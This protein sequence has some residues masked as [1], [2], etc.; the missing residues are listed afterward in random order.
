MPRNKPS[1]TARKVATDYLYTVEDPAVARLAPAGSIEATR[2]LLLAGGLIKPW[3]LSLIRS[4]AYRRFGDAAERATMPGHLLHLVLRKRFMDD[5]V[6]AAIDDGATQVLV[7]GAGFDTLCMRLAAEYPDTIFLE[8]DHP[9]T[10]ESKRRGVRKMGADTPKLH[11]A[12]VDLGK[13]NLNRVLSDSPHWRNDRVSAVVAEGVLMYLSESDVVA[14]LEAVRSSTAVGSRLLATWVFE[15]A[16]SSKEM[17]WLGGL[18]R[19]FLRLAGE[20]F[21]WGVSDAG[22]VS[23]LAAHG[24]GCDEASRFDLGTRY[25]IP[26]GEGQRRLATFERVVAATS[27]A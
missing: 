3:M 13:Q 20:P 5:E 27:L 7:V 26:A 8:V 24:F 10:S 14:F 6:R 19:V 17:G 18:V 25:L 23:F 2:S 11:L 15:G 4:P 16:L 21:R 9:P 22:I 1:A 12:G